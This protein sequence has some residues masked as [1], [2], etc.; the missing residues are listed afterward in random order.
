MS[1]FSKLYRVC[2]HIDCIFAAINTVWIYLMKKNEE[3]KKKQLACLS[4][5]CPVSGLAFSSFLRPFSIFFFWIGFYSRIFNV[6]IVIL[7]ESL[8]SLIIW[9]RKICFLSCHNKHLHARTHNSHD[10]KK[11]K[12]QN[13]FRWVFS[14][15]HSHFQW[16]D[17]VCY[18][19]RSARNFFSCMKWPIAWVYS[20]ILRSETSV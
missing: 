8:D 7:T 16:W 2:T 9:F 20:I 18:R 15:L 13:E 5:L 14:V 1:D 3:K 4:V 17:V 6:C 19:P 10:E 12:K 11:R